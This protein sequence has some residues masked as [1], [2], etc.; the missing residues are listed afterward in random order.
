MNL[1]TS[2]EVNLPENIQTCDFLVL[3][4][5]N[6][7]SEKSVNNPKSESVW[8]GGGACFGFNPKS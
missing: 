5:S 1:T 4:L 6:R 3:L 2:V 8:F 7:L